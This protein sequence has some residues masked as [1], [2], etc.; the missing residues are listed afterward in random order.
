[1]K[2]KPSSE[3]HVDIED[4]KRDADLPEMFR[5]LGVKLSKS[6]SGYKGR[7]PFHDDKSPSLGIFS[8]GNSWGWECHT[9]CGK[10]SV[11]DFVM[12]RDG[13]DE[14]RAIHILANDIPASNNYTPRSAAQAKVKQLKSFPSQKYKE[15]LLNAQELLN[16]IDKEPSSL[17]KYGLPRDAAVAMGLGIDKQENIY[18]PLH[19]KEGQLKDIKVRMV[20]NKKQRFRHLETDLEGMQ[21][22]LSPSWWENSEDIRNVLIVEGEMNGICAYITSLLNDYQIHVIGVSG[23]SSKVEEFKPL[24]SGKCVFIHT[25][26]DP[27]GNQAKVTWHEKLK[28]SGSLCIEHLNNDDLKNMDFADCARNNGMG[29][30]FKYL[31]SRIDEA[32]PKQDGK[33]IGQKGSS[34]IG[35]KPLYEDGYVLTPTEWIVQDFVQRNAINIICSFGGAGKSALASYLAVCVTCGRD[36]LGMKTFDVDQIAYIDFENDNKDQSLM[37]S[38]CSARGLGIDPNVN[39]NL[40]SKLTTVAPSEN[41]IWKDKTLPEMINNI[42]QDLEGKKSLIII[43]TF[44]IAMRVD[45]NKS[46][47]IVELMLQLRQLTHDD[48]TVLILD[49]LPKHNKNSSGADRMPSGSVQKTN[50]SRAVWILDDITPDLETGM[51]DDISGPRKRLFQ[52]HCAKLNNAERRDDLCFTRLIEDRDSEYGIVQYEI[53]V[54][55]SETAKSKGGRPSKT[56]KQLVDDIFSVIDGIMEMEGRETVIE[57]WEEVWKE[58]KISARRFKDVIRALVESD[59]LEAIGGIGIKKKYK[60]VETN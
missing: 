16:T 45:S 9:G 40:K 8:D 29:G 35:L 37:W 39:Q 53:Y 11:V 4:V 56:S 17:K 23:T 42:K 7:C 14:K 46:E 47:L 12:V 5:E 59:R 38:N 54:G 2:G 36:F 41:V 6:G 32:M 18:I 34:I 21:G 33:P 3:N 52:L 13:V 57:D 51:S 19:N 31:K 58:H 20:K 1:M 44:E 60:R 55:N 49:H 25:D 30:L 15:E 28:G 50:Q 10:G 22:W 43:D 26:N 48:N 27:A 24:I